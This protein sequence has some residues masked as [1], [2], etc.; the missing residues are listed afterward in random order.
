MHQCYCRLCCNS[1][2]QQRPWVT[3]KQCVPTISSFYM[4]FYDKN[5]QFC[6]TLPSVSLKSGL[7]CDTWYKQGTDGKNFM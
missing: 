1:V 3:L 5:F 7:I 4:I 6:S 2:S